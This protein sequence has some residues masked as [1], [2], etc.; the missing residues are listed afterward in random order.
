MGPVKC[1]GYAA[2]GEVLP[3]ECTFSGNG[4]QAR[5]IVGLITGMLVLSCALL[6]SVDWGASAYQYMRVVVHVRALCFEPGA[7]QV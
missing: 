2:V 1:S 7:G 5:C 6:Y 3:E 4:E